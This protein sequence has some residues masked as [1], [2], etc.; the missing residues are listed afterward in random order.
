AGQGQSRDHEGDAR[1][2]WM[3][4]KPLESG[5][6]SLVNGLLL[7]AAPGSIWSIYPPGET[8]FYPGQAVAIATVFEMHGTDARARFTPSTT[9]I[10][11]GAR[12][13]A[14]MP[15]P[16]REK[17]PVYLDIPDD[18]RKEIQEILL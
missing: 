5:N 6:V 9:Q 7:G 17:I 18:R 13:V 1:L 2:I 10:P 3:E 12:A 14:F 11:N 16:G 15:S 8:K 4:V